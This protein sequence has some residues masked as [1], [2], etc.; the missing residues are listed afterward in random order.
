[1]KKSSILLM[2]GGI[3]L[4]ILGTFIFRNLS[5][6]N[7]VDSHA[8]TININGIKSFSWITFTGGVFLVIGVIFNISSQV[9]K[10]ERIL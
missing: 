7:A 5:Y 3:T 9:K 10:G 4:I 8:W 1:M 6:V 2:I